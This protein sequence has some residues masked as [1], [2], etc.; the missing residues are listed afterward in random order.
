MK[1]TFYS[2]FLTHHQLPFC[3]EMQKRLG[4]DFKFVSTM[5]IFNWRLDLGFS[6]LDK[7]YDFVVRAYESEELYNEAK[8]LAL[9]SDV[10]IIRIN[11]R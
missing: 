6:D 3:L 7:E 8:Q 11:D 9:D 1:V 10:V 2:N 5:K 4:D